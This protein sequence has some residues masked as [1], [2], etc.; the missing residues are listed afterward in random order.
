MAKRATVTPIRNTRTVVQ[1]ERF[2]L[3]NSI[4][5]MIIGLLV[6]LMGT[7]IVAMISLYARQAALTEQVRETSESVA[8]HLDHS[9]DKDDYVRRDN[10]IRRA[11]EKM[12][13]KDEVNELRHSIDSQTEMLREAIATRGGRR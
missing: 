12:A 9:V 13:T 10:E 6:S 3:A 1:P 5:V 2:N 7:G 11:M 8:K 4:G